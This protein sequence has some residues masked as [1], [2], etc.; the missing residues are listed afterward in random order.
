MLYNTHD[1]LITWI[2]LSK[3]KTWLRYFCLLMALSSRMPL[4]SSDYFSEMEWLLSFPF[5]S[6]LDYGFIEFKRAIIT[7]YLYILFPII[8]HQLF[9]CRR[10]KVNGWKKEKQKERTAFLFSVK[11]NLYHLQ[12]K[13]LKPGRGKQL[14]FQL[15][16]FVK[17]T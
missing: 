17:A 14:R 8:L 10:G 1:F 7:N 13:Q 15:L 16:P 12:C 5:Y 11:G 3:F 6:R 4:K 9:S 2:F